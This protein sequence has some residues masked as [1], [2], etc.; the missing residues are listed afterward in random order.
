M[1]AVCCNSSFSYLFQ[2]MKGREFT[3]CVHFAMYFAR[4]DRFQSSF[5][6]VSWT[7]CD[8]FA[9]KFIALWFC[10]C[11][12]YQTNRPINSRLVKE[13]TIKD[14]V[15][16]VV[17]TT[18]RIRSC[19]QWTVK[20]RSTGGDS[21][22]ITLCRSAHRRLLVIV[23]PAERWNAERRNEIFSVFFL[24]LLLFF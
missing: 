16:V 23:G 10:E 12:V 17:L 11:R 9:V 13:Q 5:F 19:S 4:F 20:P 7:N 14:K 6:R 21:D 2:D 8:G 1:L 24:L 18:T 15:V 22:C 3:I